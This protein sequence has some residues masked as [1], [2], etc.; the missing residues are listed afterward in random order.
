MN[1]EDKSQFR[2]CT[3]CQMCGAVCPT[4]AISIILNEQ[5]FY[6]PHIDQKKCVD[7]SLCVKS[8]YKFDQ[9]ILQSNFES[10][11]ILAAWAKDSRIVECTTSG[12]IADI[13]AR[14]YVS[15]GYKCIGVKYDND[16][17]CAV[18]ILAD[19]EEETKQFRGSKYIQSFSIESFKALVKQCR[20]Q[21]FVVF[22]LPC[23]IYAIDKYLRLVGVRNQNILID[24]YCHGCPSLNLWKKYIDNILQISGGK[25][26][27]SVNFRSKVRGWGNFYVVVVVEG[28]EHPIEIISP[29]IND[30]F[31]ELFFSDS[32]LN[33]ACPDC[34]LRSTLEY[35]DLRLGDFWGKSYVKNFRGVSGITISS[36]VGNDIVKDISTFIECQS[37]EFTNFLPYQSYGKMY[38]VNFSMRNR[39]LS[40]LAD[41][42]MNLDDCIKEYHKLLPIKL[43]IK[44]SAKNLI[45]L[46][47]NGLISIIKNSFYKIKGT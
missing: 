30:K 47:P 42:N 22:G 23:Q 28:G 46:L 2:E 43:K 9:H 8:C 1:I 6:R 10:K 39:L 31:Y 16:T 17:N 32:I 38:I 24:L 5:G 41:R 35:C 15:Q 34:Q 29:R 25:K 12:G 36:K 18:G 19:S 7:C 3:S 14:Q 4:G 13:I 11:S 44:Y 45:K 21:K 27:L 40:I 33:D 37:Q 26:I 20:S